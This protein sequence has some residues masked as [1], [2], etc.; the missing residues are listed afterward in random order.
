MQRGARDVTENLGSF[1]LV[2]AFSCY[3]YSEMQRQRMPLGR[4]LSPSIAPCR[5]GP[6]RKQDI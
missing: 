4:L 3:L 5:E 1:M 6:E 2:Y